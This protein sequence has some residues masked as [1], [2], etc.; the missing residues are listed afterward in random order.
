MVS[1]GNYTFHMSL[2]RARYYSPIHSS[3]SPMVFTNYKSMPLSAPSYFVS[4]L[5][6]IPNLVHRNN[7]S[8]LIPT[9]SPSLS[10]PPSPSPPFHFTTLLSSLHNGIMQILCFHKIENVFLIDSYA[11]LLHLSFAFMMQILLSLLVLCG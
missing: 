11:R 4:R 2:V 3:I 6:N 10:L 1:R 7:S 8:L 5:L 9:S